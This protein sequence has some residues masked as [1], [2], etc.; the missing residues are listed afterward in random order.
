M[1]SAAA[2]QTAVDLGL[3]DDVAKLVADAPPLSDEQRRRL[4]YTFHQNTTNAAPCPESGAAATTTT[5]P[6]P[7]TDAGSP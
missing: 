3:E 2:R 1:R 6:E 5:T 7:H 4:A